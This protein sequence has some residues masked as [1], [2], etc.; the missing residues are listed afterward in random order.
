MT[1]I[2][3]QTPGKLYVAGE[4]GVVSPG[5]S[6]IIFAVDRFL[7][8]SI[9]DSSSWSLY[10]EG[11]TEETITWQIKSDGS[12]SW[13]IHKENYNLLKQIITFFEQLRQEKGLKPLHYQ[14]TI[15]SS[16]SHINGQKYGLGSSGALS[17]GLIRSLSYFYSLN[18]SALE[19]YKLAVLAQLKLQ[20]NSSFGDLA[21]SSFADMILYSSPDQKIIRQWLGRKDS[22]AEMIT[23]KWPLLNIQTLDVPSS[24][25]MTVGWTTSPSSS[26][27][28]VGWVNQ[29]LTDQS[30]FLAA[31]ELCVW[32]IAQGISKEDWK[33]F[34]QGIGDNR[35]VLNHLAQATQVSIETP[36]LTYFCDQAEH[37]EGVGKTSGAGGG[38]CGIAWF[39]D[40]KSQQLFEKEIARSD[41]IMPLNLKLFKE[42]LYDEST[43]KS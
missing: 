5:H 20:I 18:L 11:F 40:P 34:T 9:K 41:I 21:A 32:Q 22:L 25:L 38:D 23:R 29:S 24:W 4:Y 28:L 1:E 39:N 14:V 2:T 12:I 13:S 7:K 37:F 16:L 3:V 43:F 26:H 35:L 6:A 10:S 30:S 27:D 33:M 15:H 36:A 42:K 8:V 19:I 31:S 17:V